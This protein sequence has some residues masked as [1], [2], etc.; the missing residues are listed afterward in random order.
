M[1]TEQ[2][3][4]AAGVVIRAAL[5]RVRHK[6]SRIE[7]GPNFMF[8]GIL[9]GL[10]RYRDE[11]GKRKAFVVTDDGRCATLAYDTEVRLTKEAA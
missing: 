5:L 9:T 2:A 8:G 7:Y 11:N 10:R 4:D 6:G 1:G 3:G